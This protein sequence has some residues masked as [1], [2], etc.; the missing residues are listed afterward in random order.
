MKYLTILFSAL[1]VLL[2][3]QKEEVISESPLAKRRPTGGTNTVNCGVTYTDSS[4][5]YPTVTLTNLQTYHRTAIINDPSFGP[6]SHD[7]SGITF[8]AV[9]IP[10]KTVSCYALLAGP[11]NGRPDCGI[12]N[13][14]RLA[15][16]TYCGTQ[17]IIEL[18]FGLSWLNPATTY[19]GVIQVGTT[20]G[21]SYLSQPFTFTGPQF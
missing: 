5:N 9:T 12:R 16:V 13:G 1:F 4:A 18:L 21:C 6:Q 2:S 10:N 8:N 20:D 17:P 3:C 19:T 11:C 15:Q 14:I 7:V